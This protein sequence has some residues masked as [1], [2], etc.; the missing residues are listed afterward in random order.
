VR[1]LRPAEGGHGEAV[2]RDGSRVDVS[3]RRYRELTERL[4][5]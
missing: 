5:D 1:E 2:L 4:A 3:R